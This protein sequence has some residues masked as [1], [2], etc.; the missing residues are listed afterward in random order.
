MVIF[1][2]FCVLFHGIIKTR[3]RYVVQH[4]TKSSV[5]MEVGGFFVFGFLVF[6]V[7][8]VVMGE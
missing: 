1:L 5:I 6:L 3:F 4:L 8:D 7:K 2:V